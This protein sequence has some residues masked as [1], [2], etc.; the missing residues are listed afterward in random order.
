[1]LRGACSQNESGGIINTSRTSPI[2]DHRSP[3]YPQLRYRSVGIFIT[4]KIP[5]TS[6]LL[7]ENKILISRLSQ[8]ARMN[9][10]RFSSTPIQMVPHFA[11]VETMELRYIFVCIFGD[12]QLSLGIPRS[13]SWNDLL[14]CLCICRYCLCHCAVGLPLV[15]QGCRH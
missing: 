11:V 6:V 1:M 5:Q 8:S 3:R 10:I 2:N 13:C 7:Y 14:G 12:K 9:A 15:R 4:I